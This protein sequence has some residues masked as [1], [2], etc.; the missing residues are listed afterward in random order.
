[1]LHKSDSNHPEGMTLSEST[2]MSIHIYSFPPNKHFTFLLLSLSLWEFLSI[3]KTGQGLVPSHCPWWSSGQDSGLSLLQPDLSLWPGTETLLQATADQGTHEIMFGW[4]ETRA[5]PLWRNG[6]DSLT[7]FLHLMV[8]QMC[9]K[10][11]GKDRDSE[12]GYLPKASGK[13]FDFY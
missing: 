2:R 3:Q 1:M 7:F 12:I 13:A 4:G 8:F 6:P 11:M 5:H 10:E 9:L